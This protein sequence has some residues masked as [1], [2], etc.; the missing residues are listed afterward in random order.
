MVET[1]QI[2]AWFRRVQLVTSG[3]RQTKGHAAVRRYVLAQMAK[4]EFPFDWEQLGIGGS[5]LTQL[6][7]GDLIFEGIDEIKVF[8]TA[9]RRCVA[10]LNR[11]AL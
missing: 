6:R 5:P 9:A 7:Y 11:P 4:T 10:Y 8:F 2:P 1:D 3:Q